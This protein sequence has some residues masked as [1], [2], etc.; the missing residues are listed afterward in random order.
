MIKHYIT[1]SLCSFTI[2]NIIHFM[3]NSIH[4]ILIQFIIDISFNISSIHYSHLVQFSTNSPF[5][6]FLPVMN[7][8]IV[9]LNIMRHVIPEVLIIKHQ[10]QHMNM[11]CI[12][13]TRYINSFHFI[14][15]SHTHQESF[16]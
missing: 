4:S 3:N 14:Y 13:M 9:H 8:H 12:R 5:I 10:S 7:S 2:I 11:S 1:S 16:D 6:S 15:V